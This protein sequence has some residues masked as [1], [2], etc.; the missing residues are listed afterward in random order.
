[1]MMVIIHK[2]S[3]IIFSLPPFFSF[4][5][6][7]IVIIGVV[8]AI[9]GLES[10]KISPGRSAVTRR[11]MVRSELNQRGRRRGGKYREAR[12]PG[13]GVRFGRVL[14]LSCC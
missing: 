5:I 10:I 4:Y 12:P 14:A 2:E 13:S 7:V 8:G 11:K 1:M 3:R 9:P 6:R